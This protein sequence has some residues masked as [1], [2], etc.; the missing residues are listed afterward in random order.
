MKLP[1]CDRA[2]VDM[3]KLR[4]YCLN[5]NHHRGQHKARVFAAALGLTADDAE[6]LRAALLSATQ[7]YDAKPTEAIEHG[8][9]YVLDFPLSGLTGQAMVRSGWIIRKGEDFPRLTS[10]YVL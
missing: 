1:N 2:F 9:L 10:C 3:E 7:S 8:Q 4:G 6:F 5:I